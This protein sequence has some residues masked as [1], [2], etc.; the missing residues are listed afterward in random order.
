MRWPRGPVRYDVAILVELVRLKARRYRI[1][2]DGASQE[3]DAVLVAV[4]NAPSYGGGMR[5]APDADPTDGRLDVTVAAP[6]SRSTLM[7]IKPRIYAGTHVT[8]PAVST[9]R[10][11]SVGLAAEG[12]IGYA[13]G[14]R[15]APLPVQ[16]DCVPGALRVLRATAG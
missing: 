8:H 3:C 7:R 16:V 11:A 15:V 9:Y 6:I 4:A 14:E 13:D 12:I 5:I 2:L 10:A 1:T